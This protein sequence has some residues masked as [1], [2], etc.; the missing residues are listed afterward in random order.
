MKNLYFLL[1]LPFI[2]CCNT[3]I[4]ESRLNFKPYS[5]SAI[6]LIVKGSLNDTI[7]VKASAFTIIPT[8]QSRSESVR[9]FNEGNYYLS[10]NIDRPTKSLLRVGASQYTVMIFPDDTSHVELN[11]TQSAIDINFLG[12]GSTVNRYFEEKERFVG[13]KDIRSVFSSTSSPSSTFNTIKDAVDSITTVELN[14]LNNYESS[15]SLPKWFLDYEI[16]EITY[17]GA[18]YKITRPARNNRAKLFKDKL[19]DNYFNFL[20]KIEINNPNAIFSS[21]YFLFLDGYFIKDYN[22]EEQRK[23]PSLTGF[24]SYTKHIVDQS[25]T[26]LTGQVKDIYHKSKFTQAIRLYPDLLQIDSLVKLFQGIDYDNLIPTLQKGDVVKDITLKNEFDSIVTLRDY[27][28]QVVYINFWATWCGP[29]IENIPEL[30]NM[31]KKYEG[32][33]RITFI[34]ICLDSDKDKFNTGIKKFEMRGIN[35][36]ADDNQSSKLQT[37][38]NISGIPH[39]VLIDQENV[40][41]ENRTEKAPTVIR[42][43]DEMLN[44]KNPDNK[45]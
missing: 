19:P 20:S 25:N 8:G 27:K 23:S 6:H 39:Y 45:R 33:P 10:M 35:I 15:A 3:D 28:D 24:I 36:F 37:Y 41:Y 32:N 12:R 38:F 2:T 9:I 21:F 26:E 43:I 42:K 11:Q 44:Q 22:S 4:D 14:F 13:Y 16:S 7:E 30:N 31:I 18:G 5:P 34:N 29:C 1:L 40:L 17:A